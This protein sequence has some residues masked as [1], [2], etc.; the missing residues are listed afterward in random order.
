VSRR[1]AADARTALQPNAFDPNEFVL[2][3]DLR[4]QD[5]PYPRFG[6]YP[7]WDL[8][9]AGLA[10]NLSR[11]RAHLRFD[12]LPEDWQSIGKT[13]A[14]A[15]LQPTHPVLRS[16]GLY[17]SNRPHKIKTIQSNLFELQALAKWAS[18]NGLTAELWRWS[19]EDAKTYLTRVGQER[20]GSAK[21][22]AHYLLR[23]LVTFAPIFPNGGMKVELGRIS[24]NRSS[25]VSTQAIPP[26]TF[27]PL[28]RACWTYLHVF[29]KDIIA[30][31]DELER[32]E[33]VPPD[34]L[35][36]SSAEIDVALDSWLSWRQAFIPLHVHDWGR[37]LRGEPNWIGLN[38]RLVGR[39]NRN[40]FKGSGGIIR[41]Q[42]V[43]DAI[44]QGFPTR[45]GISDI[46]PAIVKRNDGTE[47]PW[48]EG[49]DHSV[50]QREITQ[51][52]N[53]AYIFVAIMTMMRDSEVQGIAAGA[54]RIHYGA[55]A[56][57]SNLRK[58]RNGPGKAELWWVSEPVIEALQVAENTALTPDRLFGS[59]R[60]GS[61]RD[62][63]GFDSHEQIRAF[64]DW[65]N[66]NTRMNGLEPIPQ[67]PLA[68][69]MFRRTMAVITANEPDGEIALG[70]TLKHNAIRALANAVT[71]G[72]GAPTAEWAAEFD[73]QR[74]EVAAGE[75]VAD[76]AQHTHGDKVFRGPGASKF[77]SGLDEVTTRASTTIVTGNERLLRN[78]LRDEFSNIRLGTLNHCL[79]DPE[80]AL[81]LERASSAVRE[82]GPIPSMCQPS[83]CRNSVITEG[84][85]PIWRNEEEELSRKL[86]DKRMARVHRLRIEAQLA[87][88]RTIT[89]QEPK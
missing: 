62:M 29:S 50:L 89:K 31:R 16:A 34:G 45:F 17:R 24:P 49:F 75:L 78:L 39:R 51:L 72:Y 80:K 60:N 41:Q 33:G 54:T 27:W 79:G 23:A 84:H 65:V 11:S 47:G 38:L 15:M 28:V 4:I 53:A 69:H 46:R 2:S 1:E 32:M 21:R 20:P 44:E 74:K 43:L 86:K 61:R 63:T 64:V 77:I 12:G 13:L 55:P 25:S 73:H 30:A 5:G 10:P 59:R 35:R 83:T 8:F 3:D 9:A 48:I 37:G 14:M 57:E 58:G 87:E 76:W 26:T 71:S 67:T 42:R 56:V 19:S 40:V 6:D 81:C 82:L 85:L 52:R 18:G 36:L 70:I 66:A 7:R 68:P 88:V 22:A